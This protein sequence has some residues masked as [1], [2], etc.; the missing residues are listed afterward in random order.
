MLSTPKQAMYVTLLLTFHRRCRN[1]GTSFSGYGVFQ[2]CMAY[3]YTWQVI[4]NTI[5]DHADQ[6]ELSGVQGTWNKSP[7][8]F[9]ILQNLLY[10]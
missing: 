5:T 6:E 9:L 10:F 1:M 3:R 2:S 4:I 7:H 8:D